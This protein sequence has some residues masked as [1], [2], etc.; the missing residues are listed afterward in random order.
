MH[1]L[2]LVASLV[3]LS[4]ALGNWWSRFTDASLLELITKPT[5]TIAIGVLGMSVSDG[6][7][8]GAIVAAI[9]AF[10]LCLAGDVALLPAV[11][12][13]VI[14]LAAF[15]I[16]HLAFVVMFVALGLPSWRLGGVALVGATAVAA[17][18]GRRIVGGATARDAKLVNPVRAYLAVISAMAIVGWATGLPAA[19]VGSTLFVASDSALGWRQFV[20]ERRW[21]PVT[22]MV[23]YHGALLGLA[24]SLGQ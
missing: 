13:F 24:L 17:V 8:R 23:T 4:A 12:R 7:P 6:A 16:G 22:I 20:L 21:M 14:G 15:L 5:A 19:I 1:G 10:G 3:A 9:I 18:L 11:D 2:T